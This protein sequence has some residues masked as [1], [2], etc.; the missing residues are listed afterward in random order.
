ML[1]FI[2]YLRVSPVAPVFLAL[3]EPAKSAK[4]NRE[5]VMPDSASSPFF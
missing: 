2:P 4:K 3:Y 1:M 5:W